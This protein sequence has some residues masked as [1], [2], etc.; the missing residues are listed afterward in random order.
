MKAATEVGIRCS[1]CH[2]TVPFDKVNLKDRCCDA[3]C[4]LNKKETEK[5]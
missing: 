1:R 5:C 3:L 4:P 2:V